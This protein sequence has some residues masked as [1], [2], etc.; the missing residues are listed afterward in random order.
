MN[1]T[2]EIYN[3]KRKECGEV[4]ETKQYKHKQIY[5]HKDNMKTKKINSTAFADHCLEQ[6]HIAG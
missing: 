1:K 4:G 6:Q 2:E 3:L 5:K